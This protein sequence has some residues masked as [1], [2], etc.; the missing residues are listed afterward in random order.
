MWDA[1]T[2][3]LDEWCA[4][5]CWDPTHVPWDS[6]AESMNLTTMPPGW[7]WGCVLKL[8]L[9]GKQLFFLSLFGV[10]GPWA[11]PEFTGGGEPL[12]PP[13]P[14]VGLATALSVASGN[15]AGQRQMAALSERAAPH[16]RRAMKLSISVGHLLPHFEKY[17]S[18]WI[19]LFYPL[20][21]IGKGPFTS[22]LSLRLVGNIFKNK[23]NPR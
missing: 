19:F 3:W 7:P 22:N 16:A 1:A 21:L 2:A 9:H 5:A 11:L 4:G 18:S 13:C 15:T 12:A 20:P 17:S 10:V 6:E 14:P 23:F 8:C